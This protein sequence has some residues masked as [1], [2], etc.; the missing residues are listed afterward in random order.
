M[1]IPK[2]EKVVKPPSRPTMRE[3]LGLGAKRLA[4]LREAGEKADEEAADRI[5]RQGSV[6]KAVGARRALH[7]RSED[8]AHRRADEAARSDEKECHVPA[9]PA[10]ARHASSEAARPRSG[11]STPPS[12]CGRPPLLSGRAAGRLTS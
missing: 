11:V 12:G 7:P 4:R 2:A 1:S 9:S 5:D 8:V 6:G 10:S 3:G